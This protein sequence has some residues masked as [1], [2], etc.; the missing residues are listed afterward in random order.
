[1]SAIVKLNGVE[2]PEVLCIVDSANH[3]VCLE[4][5]NTAEQHLN[6]SS[7]HVEVN[8]FGVVDL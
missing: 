6:L 2:L 5:P 4:T 7:V 3:D 8:I 1:M